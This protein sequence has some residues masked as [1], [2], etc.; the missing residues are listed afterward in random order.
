LI[1]LKAY[2]TMLAVLAVLFAAAIIDSS[3]RGHPAANLKDLRII[4]PL[5]PSADP[6]MNNSARY[7]RHLGLSTPGS[8][9][10]DFPGQPDYLPAGMMWPPPLLF[11][12]INSKVFLSS[13]RSHLKKWILV[14]R[15]VVP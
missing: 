11:V 10:P 2:L 5:L 1:Y 4:S 6:G 7:I 9:F 8:A 14:Q 15:E 13:T 12:G 3:I